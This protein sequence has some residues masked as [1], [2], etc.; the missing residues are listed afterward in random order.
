MTEPRVPALGA[1]REQYLPEDPWQRRAAQQAAQLDQLERRTKF[2]DLERYNVDAVLARPL[3]DD[4][5]RRA[6]SLKSKF[7]VPTAQ[8]PLFAGVPGGQQQGQGS[9]QRSSKSRAQADADYEFGRKIAQAVRDAFRD[10]D[11]D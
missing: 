11:N 10:A 5:R 7:G 6:E 2:G 8:R 9:G 4:N 1:G 3:S